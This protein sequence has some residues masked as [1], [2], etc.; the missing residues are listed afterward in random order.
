MLKLHNLFI[1][2]IKNVNTYKLNGVVFSKSKLFYWNYIYF[3][4][5]VG[6]L[7]ILK[8]KNIRHTNY[9]NF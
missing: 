4:K 8:F 3:K 1:Y 6:F 2:N 9:V 5:S 7:W